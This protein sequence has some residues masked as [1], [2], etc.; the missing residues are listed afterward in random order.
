MPKTST[1]RHCLIWINEAIVRRIEHQTKAPAAS[2]RYQK[3]GGG[4][5]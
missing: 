1:W 5:K 4:P 3:P 2:C